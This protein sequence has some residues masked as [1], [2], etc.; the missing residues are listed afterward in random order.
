LVVDDEGLTRQ[1]LR[2][3]LQRSGIEVVDAV[4]DGDAAI[5]VAMTVATDVILM[6]L[7]L[8]SGMSG[9][10]CIERLKM[11]G[12]D[13][14]VLVL[15][16]TAEKE[17]VL[18]AIFAGAAGYVLKTAEPDE[19][20]RA[21]KAAADGN[22]FVSGAIAAVL[23]AEIRRLGPDTIRSRDDAADRITEN[24]T[25]RELEILRLVTAG[26]SNDEI[27][28]RLILSPQTVKNHVA[29]ILTKLRLQNRLQA[30][31]HAVRSG[32]F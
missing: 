6:D 11:S 2:M 10:E 22:A 19:L 5:D 23:L 14:P 8:G 3:S 27:S 26:R 30:A 18:E 25:Q 1:A 32:L 31:V 4:G 21:V 16:G 15:T 9:V 7:D 17:A 20:V 12:V 13:A 29:A 28:R 24:L